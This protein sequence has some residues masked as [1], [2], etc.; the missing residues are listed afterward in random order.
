MSFIE[1][2]VHDVKHDGNIVKGEVPHLLYECP[3]AESCRKKNDR[4]EVQKESGNE[5]Q[6]DHLIS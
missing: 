1:E 3:K 2:T 5:N 4:V 6:F